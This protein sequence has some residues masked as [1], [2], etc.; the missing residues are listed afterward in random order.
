MFLSGP[1]AAG[2]VCSFTVLS[3]LASGFPKLVNL[4]L[5]SCMSDTIT[6]TDTRFPS[7][8]VHARALSPSGLLQL[9]STLGD[10]YSR[11]YN[12]FPLE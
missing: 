11:F 8:Q 10:F 6:Q 4:G 2:G 9:G 1:S 5:P 12:V 3:S 7:Q